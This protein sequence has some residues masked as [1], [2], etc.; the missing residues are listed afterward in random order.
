MYENKY[1]ESLHGIHLF[2]Y[3][4]LLRQSMA[5]QKLPIDMARIIYLSIFIYLYIYMTILITNE[6]NVCICVI[7]FSCIRKYLYIS[8]WVILKQ[9]DTRNAF[10][11][12]RI[13]L[14]NQN[15]HHHHHHHQVT[16][17]EK[18]LSLLC[19]TIKSRCHSYKRMPYMLDIAIFHI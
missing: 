10:I 17:I 19:A 1:L 2:N 5:I 8:I 16:K 9:K 15:Y 18:Y 12:S 13:H 11:L 3:L 4:I 6:P 7:S 14:F